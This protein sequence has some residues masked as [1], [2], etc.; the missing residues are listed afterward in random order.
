MTDIDVYSITVNSPAE[1]KHVAREAVAAERDAIAAEIRE[2]WP[3]LA[4]PLIALLAR[5]RAVDDKIR[6]IN[7][8]LPPDRRLELVEPPW[9]HQPERPGPS[10]H[11]IRA[12]Q[13]KPLYLETNIPALHPG[14]C[15]HHIPWNH[16]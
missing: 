11:P 6:T 9:R 13:P 12:F 5:E 2:R 7:V 10:I 4:A 14:D 8:A 15:S 16:R 3:V 1:H